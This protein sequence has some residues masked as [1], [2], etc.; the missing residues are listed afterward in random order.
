MNTA[1]FNRGNRP[2]QVEEPFGLTTWELDWLQSGVQARGR[3]AHRCVCEGLS[4]VYF[5][6]HGR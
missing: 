5:S 3:E 4:M 2:M 1:G 6:A